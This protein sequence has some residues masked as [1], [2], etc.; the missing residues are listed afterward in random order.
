MVTRS[1]N[2]PTQAR[3]PLRMRRG[4]AIWGL[5]WAVVG[6]VAF[7]VAGRPGWAAAC[8]VVAVL[9][10]VDLAMVIRHIHQGAHYQPG[11]DVPP[12]E[13]DRGMAKR[14]ETDAEGD[15]SRYRGDGPDQHHGHDHGGG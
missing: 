12:Y 13:P 1:G 7:A 10:T 3:S 11:D 15:C 5:V 2:E 4:F 6:A 9:A 8:A 14:S